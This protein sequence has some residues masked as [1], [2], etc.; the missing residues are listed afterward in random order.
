MISQFNGIVSKAGSKITCDQASLLFFAAERTFPPR[1]NEGMPDRR[2][3]PK[4][5]KIGQTNGRQT[6]YKNNLDIKETSRATKLDKNK[7]KN[8]QPP[9]KYKIWNIKKLCQLIVSRLLTMVNCDGHIFF[10]LLCLI[11]PPFT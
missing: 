3:D 9:R 1:K 2:L 11:S 4:P 5:L 10:S 6:H 8:N 7:G